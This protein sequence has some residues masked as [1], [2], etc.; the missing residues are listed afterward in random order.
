MTKQQS[1]DRFLELERTDIGD[2]DTFPSLYPCP[3][4]NGRKFK[5]QRAIDEQRI[6][7]IG[8]MTALMV[9]ATYDGQHQTCINFLREINKMFDALSE[10]GVS[11][12]LAAL[13]ELRPPL[14]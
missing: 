9:K 5:E 10:E 13:A 12:H 2:A 4:T 6:E 1:I 14:G 8:T 7:L 11:P 3:L